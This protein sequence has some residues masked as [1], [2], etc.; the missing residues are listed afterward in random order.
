MV[1]N[2]VIEKIVLNMMIKRV[3]TTTQTEKMFKKSVYQKVS[4]MNVVNNFIK[5]KNK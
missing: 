4:A 2:M 5:S 3:I 1:T